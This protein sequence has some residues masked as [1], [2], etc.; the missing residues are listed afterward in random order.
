[1]KIQGVRRRYDW[2]SRIYDKFEQPME[3]M[4]FK[5][6]RSPIIGALHGRIL[7]VGV[8]TGKNIPFYQPRTQVTG[9]DISPK[10]LINATQKIS[11]FHGDRIDLKL[12]NVEE[13]SFKDE[14]FDI[15]LCTFVLCSVPNP[16][17]AVQE[18][19]RVLKPR[20]RLV[21][22]EHVLSK[23]SLIAF[24]QKLV[25][26]FIRGVFGYNIDRDTVGNVKRG[27]AFILM[28]HNLTKTDMLKLLVCEKPAQKFK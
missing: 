9:I 8:G 11:S 4:V 1:M 27:K 17:Q 19:L 26:P 14:T 7:E 25:N 28:D 3:Q 15:V 2:Y 23:V 13:L 18:M 12:M 24:L 10:M 22:L 5:D 16:I 20:G 6:L 21:L